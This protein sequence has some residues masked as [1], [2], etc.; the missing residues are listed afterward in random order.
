MVDLRVPGQAPGTAGAVGRRGVVVTSGIVDPRALTRPVP[1]AEQVEAA[2]EELVD[3]LAAA[4]ASSHD[5]VRVEAFLAE[6]ADLAKWNV[7]FGRCWPSDP[8]ARTTLVVGFVVDTLRFE[9]Q[10]VAILD[11]ASDTSRS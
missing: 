7:A 8:P 11:E 5:V 2:L 4:G 10:A 3:V 6:A 1:V 9:V